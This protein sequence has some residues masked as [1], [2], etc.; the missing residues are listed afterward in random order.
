MNQISFINN[1]LII[2]D[3]IINIV[4]II[5]ISAD[6]FFIL[7]TIFGFSVYWNGFLKLIYYSPRPFW[8]ND[9]LFQYCETGY[10]NPSGHAMISTI[11]YLGII[12][13]LIQRK[14]FNK[15]IR[16]FLKIIC[17]FVIYNIMLSRIH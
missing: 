5:Y 17:F 15:S 1:N 2:I 11:F 12:E 7:F 3:L 6:L 13:I 4:I 16:Y 10:G 14:K 9:D 8:I